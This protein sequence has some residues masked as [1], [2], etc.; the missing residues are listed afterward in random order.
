MVLCRNGRNIPIKFALMLIVP[1][2]HPAFESRNN[3]FSKSRSVSPRL[4]FSPDTFTGA[5][6]VLP[7]SWGSFA[8]C[9]GSPEPPAK[10]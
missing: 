6:F 5:R 1:M 4:S 7:K 3:S 2:S 8:T 9:L 10:E